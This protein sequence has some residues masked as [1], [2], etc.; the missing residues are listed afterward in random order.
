MIHSV[1]EFFE[2]DQISHTQSMVAKRSRTSRATDV[3]KSFKTQRRIPIDPA[4]LAAIGHPFI[5]TKNAGAWVSCDGRRD[6]KL[7][8]YFWPEKINISQPTN[9]LLTLFD[10]F[11][12]LLTI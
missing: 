1:M 10:D 6:Q 8:T 5:A 11:K 4:L 2:P 3:K 9:S 7:E 12:S